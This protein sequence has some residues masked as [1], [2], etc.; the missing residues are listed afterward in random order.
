M[1]RGEPEQTAY[2]SDYVNHPSHYETGSFECIDV[3]EEC[4]GADAVISFCVCNAFKYV[5]RW[6]NKNGIEDL[7][8]AQWYLAKA[9]HMMEGDTN[10]D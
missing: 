5:Y 4:Q 9:I 8:K 10:E 1:K 7:K 2:D 3:M 6:Q